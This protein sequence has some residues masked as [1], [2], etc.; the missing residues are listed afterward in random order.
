LKEE[1]PSKNQ[2]INNKKGIYR[3]TALNLPNPGAAGPIPAGGTK[4]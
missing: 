2:R 4:Y 3:K 1:N